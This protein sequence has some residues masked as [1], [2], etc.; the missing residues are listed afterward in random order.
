[1]NFLNRTRLPGWV[2]VWAALTLAQNA[3][4]F[5]RSAP[6]DQL[7]AASLHT[8]TFET[9]P[10]QQNLTSLLV[11]G[12]SF[13]SPAGF[14]ITQTS[15]PG[16]GISGHYLHKTQDLHIT[17][18][19]PVGSVAFDFETPAAKDT[20]IGIVIHNDDSTELIKSKGEASHYTLSASPGT[21]I[22]KVLFHAIGDGS[23][24][25]ISLDQSSGL[26]PPDVPAASDGTI[27]LSQIGDY[28][29]VTYDYPG[30]AI[31]DTV[32][33]RWT[34]SPPH[35]DAPVQRV[36][37]VGP[38]IFQIPKS[39]I[40]GDVGNDATLTASVGVGDNPLVISDPKVIHVR[41]SGSDSGGAT[42]AR[43]NSRYLDT[44]DT[45][46]GN[47]PA[48]YCNGIIIRSVDNGNFAPWD[49][50]P[51]A[52]K[53]GAVSFSYMRVDAFVENFYRK[54]GFIFLPQAEALAQGKGMDYLC[55]YAYDAGTIVGPRSAKGCGLKPRSA[56]TVDFSTCAS[57]N[58]V[59]VQG[60]YAYTR[61]IRNRDYQ[62]SLSTQD[63]SQFAVSYKVRASRPDNMEALW[64]EMMVDLWPQNHGAQLPIEA[65]F[66]KKG[67][68]TSRGDAQTFQ[69]KFVS[70][71]GRWVPVIA[72]D[73]DHLEG[74][75]F[76]YNSSDQAV[77]P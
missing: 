7:A 73:L 26:P 52:I 37:K 51:S 14:E 41:D 77:Q 67:D 40:A 53:L 42:A 22:A 59:T 12:V 1:M 57:V 71:T 2:A 8:I 47:Q 19:S 32:G 35:F 34:G 50:S 24:D 6:A 66:Y 30:M 74:A 15:L 29:E 64:N 58:A 31:A 28:L 27:D 69:T 5:D 18:S 16:A 68:S 55:I 33:M 43:L 65:F 60:W 9:Q 63:P 36:T 56:L 70:N 75:P 44:A 10:I 17:P 46:A 20:V 48:Y 61:T 13:S 62:C 38:L 4:A 45:C 25:N 21:L 11:D 49:P 76:S 23:I 54:A 3:L 39:H 72:L